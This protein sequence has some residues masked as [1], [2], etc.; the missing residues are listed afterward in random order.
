MDINTLERLIKKLRAIDDLLKSNFKI[1]TDSDRETSLYDATANIERKKTNVAEIPKTAGP[2]VQQKRY[3]TTG[4]STDAARLRSQEREQRKA[5]KKS[6]KIYTPE[7][8]EEHRKKIN[9]SEE[10]SVSQ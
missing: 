1:K 4:S 6:L 5:S 3:T 10:D 8:I 9:K 7:E 2:N